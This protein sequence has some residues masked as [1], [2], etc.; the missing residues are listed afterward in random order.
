VIPRFIDRSQPNI[1]TAQQILAFEKVLNRKNVIVLG[2]GLVGV[3]TAEVLAGYGN[4]VTVVDMLDTAAPLAPKRPR[5]N[6]MAHLK[7]L[8][9]K[10]QLSSRVL[11]IHPDGIDYE[12]EGQEHS[13]RGFDDIILAFGSRSDTRLSE[14]LEDLSNVH[15]IGDASKA[16]D[17]KKAIFEATQ[18]A[19][20]L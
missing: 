18:L 11:A 2:A 6:L 12:C 17:A 3:E 20:K 9:V 15:M 14:T 19:L 4:D 7:K 16:G 10:L 13:L 8:N 1:F 5:E